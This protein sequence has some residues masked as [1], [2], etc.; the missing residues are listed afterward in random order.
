MS[1]LEQ[2]TKYP[3][4]IDSIEFTSEKVK[5]VVLSLKLNANPGPGNVTPHL[6]SRVDT[7]S[8]II[9]KLFTS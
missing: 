7:M 2:L 3:N 4:T 5:K 6:L 8:Q 1:S 9:S